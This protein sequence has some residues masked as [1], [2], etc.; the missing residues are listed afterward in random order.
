[1]KKIMTITAIGL[2]LGLGL[3]AFLLRAVIFEQF[4]RS[5]SMM[6]VSELM[7]QDASED[8]YYSYANASFA[9]EQAQKRY[10]IYTSLTTG[11]TEQAQSPTDA[12]YSFLVQAALRNG[13]AFSYRVWIDGD[14]NRVWVSDMPA[15]SDIY[16]EADAETD[17]EPVAY[18][19]TETAAGA[20]LKQS[21]FQGIYLSNL[22]PL[23]A[24]LQTP[25]MGQPAADPE[26]GA[27]S[28]PLYAQSIDL[29]VI[30]PGRNKP[31]TFVRSHPEQPPAIVTVSDLDRLKLVPT[32]AADSVSLQYYALDV[33]DF[34]AA[35]SGSFDL[36]GKPAVLPEISGHYIVAYTLTYGGGNPNYRGT[37][38]G[39]FIMNLTSGIRPRTAFNAYPQGVV[40][41]IALAHAGP[42][43]THAYK[44]Q[45]PFLDTEIPFF[46]VDGAAAVWFPI[47]NA[48]KPGDYTAKIFVQTS[49]PSPQG[50]L[51]SPWQEIAAVAFAIEKR[52]FTRQD[53]TATASMS[54]L[55]T[56][57]NYAFDRE[58][59]NAAKAQSNPEPYWSGPF[60]LPVEGRFS[61]Y[62]GE[63]RY[64]N[65]VYTSNH[66]AIDIA[67]EADVPVGATAAGKVVLAYPLRVSGTTVI[68]DHGA[69]IFSTYCH[70]NAYNVE[71]G[72]MVEAGDIIGLVGSTGY[73]TG[74]HLHF[75]V[76]YFFT[77]FD[78]IWLMERDLLGEG[79]NRLTMDN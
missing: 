5:P 72:D 55:A 64:T 28:V 21:A 53:L 40:G 24:Q 16:S 39:T 78:P 13:D 57:E 43:E 22:W 70:L 45:V 60:V 33:S 52:T 44:L 50:L 36:T 3:T 76:Q 56:A 73:S 66:N 12:P 8:S 46:F 38:S 18:L 20:L 2:L 6:T 15:E 42:P 79:I 34:A 37:V 25:Y 75:A 69:G 1:M 77:G 23:A 32:E 65:G 10:D 54:S 7:T 47:G 19:L 67:V 58:K 30:H 4:D 29:R 61:T 17:S 59:T 41:C 51:Q 31:L 68:I 49:V 48:V 63:E 62:Y 26:A 35:A 9:V 27:L 11:R 71:E 14:I 74:P